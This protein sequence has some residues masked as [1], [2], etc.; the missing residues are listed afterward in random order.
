MSD[1]LHLP[2]SRL[3]HRARAL[4]KGA[5][6]GHAATIFRNENCAYLTILQEGA[7]IGVFSEG[8]FRSAL[9]AGA[10]LESPVD[11]FL[12][13][14]WLQLEP[15]TTGA[16]ALRLFIDQGFNFAVVVDESAQVRGV[17]C[18]SD[19]LQPS[20][21]RPFMPPVGGLATPIGVYLTTTTV[22]AGPRP[23]GLISSG[24]YMATLFVAAKLFSVGIG[25]LVAT[26][27]VRLSGQNQDLLALPLFGLL[28]RL[29][30][31]AGIHAAE[32]MAVHAIERQEPLTPEV[33][34][35]MPR[36]HPRC[37]TNMATAAMIVAVFGFYDFHQPMWLASIQFLIAVLV[38]WA[39]YHKLGGLVQYW[40]TTKKPNQ[41]QIE[42]GCRSANALVDQ[43]A[44][45]R[46]TRGGIWGRLFN[47]GLFHVLV[48]GW[49]TVTIFYYLLQFLHRGDLLN[50]NF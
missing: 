20:E 1:L 26:Q 18:P 2:V 45:A 30:P 24:A 19:L 39:G 14:T 4:E 28:M 41:K 36:V 29:S 13:S 48:G 40:V 37:G 16:E 11:S 27:H 17:L 23:W 43:V 32:H 6:L 49:I 31:L 3:V 12:D 21:T 44:V 42:M 50:F 5:S 9:S 10:S 38:A 15:H 22:W 35:R 25:H 46:Y 34:G 33:V 8:G 47:A 7:F